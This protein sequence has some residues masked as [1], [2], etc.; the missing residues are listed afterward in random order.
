MSW[1][2]FTG[3]LIRMKLTRNSTQVCILGRKLSEDG[4]RENSEIQAEGAG[5]T[6]C[7]KWQGPP[8]KTS[9]RGP[10]EDDGV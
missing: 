5:V 2:L 7:Q 4:Q 6:A 1:S 8:V 3:A 9:E 10:V